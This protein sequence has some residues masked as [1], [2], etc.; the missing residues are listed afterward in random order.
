[1]PLQFE[2]GQDGMPIRRRSIRSD[3]VTGC[4]SRSAS[5]V[6]AFRLCH[7]SLDIKRLRRRLWQYR[8]HSEQAEVFPAPRQERS[9]PEWTLVACTAVALIGATHISRLPL[10]GA[11]AAAVALHRRAE[12]MQPQQG[13]HEAVLLVRRQ[14]AVR[15]APARQS[16]TPAEHIPDRRRVASSSS[17]AAFGQI[18]S[19][20]LRRKLGDLHSASSDWPVPASATSNDRLR[21]GHVIGDRAASLRCVAGQQAHRESKT[22]NRDRPCRAC[23][24]LALPRPCLRHGRSPDRAA[25]GRRACC[26]PPSVHSRFKRA[27]SALIASTSRICFRCPAIS[28]RRHLLE[29]ELQAARQHGHRDFLRIGR[30]QDEL[31]VLRRLFERLQHRVERRVREHVHFVDDI[32]LEAT[33]RRRIDRVLE[34]LAHL[35]DLGIGRRI[36]FQQVD[37]AARI[38]FRASR[39]DAAGRLP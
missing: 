37:K 31:D 5:S 38:D 33:T 27:G 12:G 26:P 6:L 30:R 15:C 14:M 24:A 25:T 32:D 39:T 19:D 1:M 4:A 23:R 20:R 18:V 28:R 11:P 10:A 16:D 8:P 34:Q 21:V 36:D 9:V 35:V 2:R 3:G 22:G 17:R 13:H 7:A 29:I